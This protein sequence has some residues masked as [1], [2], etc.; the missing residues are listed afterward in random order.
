MNKDSMSKVSVILPAYNSQKYIKEAVSSILAQTFSDFTLY[1]I[2]DGSSDNT[3]Q[4]LNEFKDKRINI[5]SNDGNRGLIYSLNR[6]LE[7][8]KDSEYV[9]RMDADDIALPNRFEEQIKFL[10]NNPSVGVLGTAVEYFSDNNSSIKKMYRPNNH[11][12]ILSTLLFYNPIV[13]PTVMIRNSAMA[14]DKF[15]EDLPKYE[16]YALWINLTTKTS[17]ANLE[18]VLLKYRQHEMSITHSYSEEMGSN[19]L[20]NET[21]LSR[22]CRQWG[23]TL[24]EQEIRTLSIISYKKRFGLQAPYTAIFLIKTLNSIVKKL[25]GEFDKK[26]FMNIFCERSLLYFVQ[27][28]RIKEFFKFLILYRNDKTFLLKYVIIGKR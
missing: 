28:R 19:L 7:Y 12:K 14:G 1:I 11:S 17:F 5:V 24:T 15:P 3:L 10:D 23:I 27:S 13:H 2:N 4:I 26:Y 9:A 16:D 22:Y 25:P 18:Q 21:L 8:S 20:A 6:G